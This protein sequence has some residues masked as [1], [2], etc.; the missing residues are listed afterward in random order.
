MLAQGEASNASGTL[1]HGMDGG[2][3]PEERKNHS[4][5]ALSPLRG[6][7]FLCLVTQGFA[8]PSAFA[9]PWANI[10]RRSAAANMRADRD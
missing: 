1:G 8:W 7:L 6:Y 5:F 10:G 3:A 4:Q 2:E 9:S